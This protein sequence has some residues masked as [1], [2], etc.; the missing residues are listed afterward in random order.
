MPAFTL[1][2]SLIVLF[3]QQPN[4]IAA[5]NGTIVSQEA[6]E[7]APFEK[8]SAMVRRYYSADEVDAARN[9]VAVDCQRIRY[10]S[11]GLQV[12][13]F[14]VKLRGSAERKLPILVYNRGGFQEMG[15]LDT[16]NLLDFYGFAARGFIVVASQY[17]GNDGGEGQDQ[18]GGADVADVTNLMALARQLPDADS[19]NVFMY[20]LSRGGMMTFLALRQGVAINAA[21]VVGAMYDLEALQKHLPNMMARAGT[22]IPG[23]DQR[24][25]EILRERSVLNWSHEIHVPVLIIHGANDANVPVAEALAFATQLNARHHRYELIVYAD[26][27]HEV[28]ES[29]RDRDARIVA[30]FDRHKK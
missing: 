12:V 5:P 6:C 11:D 7:I 19:N 23:F 4:P 24:G 17:R 8:Q 20:G 25:S 27:G 3:W 16:W 26:D 21:A 22:L 28:M 9:G 14:I 15:K 13:G 29:R 10:V 1:I 30:W 18:V 2:L